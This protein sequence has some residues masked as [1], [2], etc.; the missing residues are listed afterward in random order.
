MCQENET[1]SLD[2]LCGWGGGDSPQ[3]SVVHWK[4]KNLLIQLIP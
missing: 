3:K 4:G 1:T 2:G